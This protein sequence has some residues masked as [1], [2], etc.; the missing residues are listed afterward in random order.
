MIDPGGIPAP[1]PPINPELKFQTA[2]EFL[3]VFNELNVIQDQLNKR[4]QLIRDIEKL[5][6]D[7]HGAENRMIAYVVRF[8]HSRSGI[9]SSDI[10]IF[11]ALLNSI[12]G[13]EQINILMHSPGGDGTVVEKMVE[14]CRA[15]LVN[16]SRK[17]RVIVPNIAKSAATLFALGADEI[18]MGYCSELGPIDPQVPISVSGIVQWISALAFVE[19][20]DTLM[21]NIAEAIRKKEPT[22]GQL[23]QLAGLN[24]PFTH[25]MEN[26]IDF[27]KKS[28]KDRSN[29]IRQIH[30]EIEISERG[31]AAQES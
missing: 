30:V 23:Q 13:A 27:A 24:I 25:E 19:S 29:F 8:A 16:G 15:H 14:M 4:Q 1:P 12:S 26:W 20:R 9:N 3:A 11:E 28:Q 22:T 18:L 21:R 2:P 31:R 6:T 7:R 10:A 17:L 5:L